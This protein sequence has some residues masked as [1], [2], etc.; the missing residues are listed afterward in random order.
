MVKFVYKPSYVQVAASI[1]PWYAAAMIPLALANVL[2]N[3]LLARPASKLPLALG[4]FILALGYIF[5]LLQFHSSLVRVL[6]VMGICN[7]LLLA[8]CASFSIKAKTH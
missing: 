6:Q 2:L 1:L 7:L 3:Q 5:A 4:V 8:L